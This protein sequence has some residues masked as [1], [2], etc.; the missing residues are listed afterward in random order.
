MIAQKTKS[1]P[2]VPIAF[3]LFGILA[4]ILFVLSQNGKFGN[5]D[6]RNRASS[7]SGTV[8]ITLS[9]GNPGS[10]DTSPIIY[11]VGDIITLD[12]MLNT[13]NTQISG[14]GFR[15]FYP[16][17]GSVP[18]LQPIKDDG[19]AANT[20]T[21]NASALSSN[22]TNSLNTISR[23]AGKV[24]I[25]YLATL[26]PNQSFT[27]NQGQS[28]AAIRLKAIA[29]KTL[30]KIEAE[31][32]GSQVTNFTGGLDNLLTISPLYVSIV[33]DTEKPT[34]TV[35]GMG[36][37]ASSSTT[38]DRSVQFNFT[39]SDLPVR[40]A[41]TSVPLKYAYKYD[42]SAFSAYVDMPSGSTP[43]ELPIKVLTNGS[44]T[45]TINV[46]DPHGNIGAGTKTI[47]VDAQ[48]TLTSAATPAGATE[49]MAGTQ[50]NLV[51]TNFTGAIVKF[52]TVTCAASDYLTTPARTN[53][54]MS[55]KVPVGANGSITVVNATTTPDLISNAMPFTARTGITITVPLGGIT[56]A[57]ATHPDSTASVTIK[58][59]TTYN[60]T[61]SDQPLVW[62]ST[63]PKGYKFFGLL[64]A[65]PEFS[66]T[67][68]CS[69]WVKERSRLAKKF[70]SLSVV[71]TKNNTYDKSAAANTLKAGDVA[72]A[73]NVIQLQD[74]GV[75]MTN[76]AGSAADPITG[77]YKIPVTDANAKYDLDGNN[78]IEAHDVVVLLTN[79]SS[80]QLAGDAQ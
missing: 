41:N 48:P 9:P 35:N 22:F 20:I 36:Q 34:V 31:P 26:G 52:G 12:A 38:T 80:L 50:V 4:I 25:D 72:L 60:Q 42:S 47:T 75:L 32:S 13:V 18:Q 40:A 2:V 3:A 28:L 67:K 37:L 24:T 29:A 61:I 53:T 62:S 73:D 14:V 71:A 64:P 1:I 27:N 55:V 79:L 77:L 6:I 8:T 59:G 65:N 66:G 58:C 51:G 5:F 10:T 78:F 63:T 23:A 15:L 7:P 44:H 16:Y 54:T 49:G 21:S 33:A 11:Y 57:Q 17:T 68:S 70:N 46:K 56:T 69:I 30:I 74:F 43:V 39:A 19:S 76:F 45:V